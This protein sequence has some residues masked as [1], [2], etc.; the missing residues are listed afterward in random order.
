M[1]QDYKSSTGR[2]I[3]S[4]E[5]PALVISGSEDDITLPNLIFNAAGYCC[6]MA[7]RVFSVQTQQ[8][9]LFMGDCTGMRMARGA[10]TYLRLVSL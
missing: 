3:G 1:G 5:P 9:R 10:S 8:I 7:A 6:G 2:P 4:I